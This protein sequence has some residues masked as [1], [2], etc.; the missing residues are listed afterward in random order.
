MS[1][2]SEHDPRPTER[3]TDRADAYV[4]YRPDYPPDAIDR[5]LGG[6]GDPAGLVAADVGAGTGISARLLAGR[7]VRVLAIEPN[8]AMR[9][10]MERRP[11]VEP[12]EGTAEATGLPDASVDL[13]L[14]AQA[15]HWFDRPA[16]LREFRRILRGNAAGPG[17]LA[18]MANLADESDPMTAAYVRAV[19]RPGVYDKAAYEPE[20]LEEGGLFEVEETAEFPHAQPLDEGGL[21]GRAM[22]AS[23]VPREGPEAERTAAA[24]RDAYE[25]HKDGMGRVS[26]VYRTRVILATAAG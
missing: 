16:T 7:G 15:W 11:L 23:Y 22:S 5:I 9:E 12:R 14:A 1:R 6:L 3:F 21:I 18:V 13:V 10:A 19:Q 2:A 4:R 17:R 20:T 25:R 8:R 24:L 26:L